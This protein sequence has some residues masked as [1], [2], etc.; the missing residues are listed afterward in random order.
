[1]VKVIDVLL[2]QRTIKVGLLFLSSFFHRKYLIRDNFVKH[3]FGVSVSASVHFAGKK[4]KQYFDPTFSFFCDEKSRL[5]AS[6]WTSFVTTQRRRRRRHRRCRVRHSYHITKDIYLQLKA[7]SDGQIGH[8]FA[9]CFKTLSRPTT[10]RTI[11]IQFLNKV[12]Q[13]L[14]VASN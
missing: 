10:C 13:C 9:F 8:L 6:Q 4:I 1:M 2:Y 7:F 12:L 3:G 11:L 14:F 5:W